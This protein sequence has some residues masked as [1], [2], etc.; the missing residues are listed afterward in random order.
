M[1]VE[2][3]PL[4]SCFHHF[5]ATAASIRAMCGWLIML[6]VFSTCLLLRKKNRVRVVYGTIKKYLT[7][8]KNRMGFFSFIRNVNL[9]QIIKEMLF[10]LI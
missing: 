2:M 8:F 9:N 4:S 1:M 10:L 5:A 7:F 6:I 3:K